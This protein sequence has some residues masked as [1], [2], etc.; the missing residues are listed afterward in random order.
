MKFKYDG[1]D[2]NIRQQLPTHLLLRTLVHRPELIP[3]IEFL[4][5][6][7]NPRDPNYDCDMLDSCV[8]WTRYHR[9]AFSRTS[10]NLA[11]GL[12]HSLDPPLKHQ[13]IGG[14]RKGSFKFCTALLISQLVNLKRIR[15]HAIFL[16]PTGFIPLA[17]GHSNPRIIERRFP[18]VEHV[19]TDICNWTYDSFWWIT[20]GAILPFF[21]LPSIKTLGFVILP[22]EMSWSPLSPTSTLTSLVLDCFQPSLGTLGQILLANPNLKALKFRHQFAMEEGRIY[23]CGEFNE[24]LRPV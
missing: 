12:I 15:L 11:V 6:S 5:L 19:D 9:S 16:R 13:W 8:L 20:R 7:G 21:H 22:E 17:F 18:N 23:H 4:E 2:V 24:A 10:M 3:L 14:L 1:R